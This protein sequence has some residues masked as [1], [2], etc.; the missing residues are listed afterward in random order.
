[1]EKKDVDNIFS[2]LK[3]AGVKTASAL[4]QLLS[5]SDTKAAAA[6]KGDGNLSARDR[7]ISVLD[8]GTFVETGAYMKRRAAEFDAPN[9]SPD[10]FEGVITGYGAVDGRLV[11]VFAQDFSR[12]KGAVSE[13]QAKK[14]AS[15]YK[16]AV[17]NGAPVIG[18]FDSAGAFVYDGIRAMSGFGCVMSCASSASGIVPQIALVCGPCS[19]SAA[20]IAGM[21]DFTVVSE[22]K[23]SVYVNSPFLLSQG[24]GSADYA[25]KTGFAALSA[26][27]DS[28]C[29][30]LLHTLINYLPMNNAE[31]TVRE[32]PK[33]E[34]NK[35]VDVSSVMTGDDYDMTALLSLIADSGKYLELY[36]GYAPEMTVGFIS[37]GGTVCGICANQPK[38]KS[39][40]L[41]PSASRKASRFVSF[42]DCFNIPVIT[43]VDS[44]GLDIS[45]EAEG[46]PYASELAK[47]AS[48]YA[49]AKTPLVTLIAGRAYGAVYT[50]MGSKSIGADVAFALDTAKIGAMPAQSAVAFLWNDKIGT[51]NGDTDTEYT[52]ESLEKQ[53]DETL[54]SAVEAAY[55]GEIDDIIDSSEIRQR[56]AAAVEMLSEKSKITPVKRHPNMPL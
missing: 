41:S 5:D 37:L 34:I 1:M 49:S 14:I 16:L 20:V 46:S 7:I 38:V 29:I 10:A 6:V 8:D 3:N 39:G 15:V 35:L 25:K 11:F 53:W 33:D 18:I 43:I 47:L 27:N 30:S 19:G 50:V 9:T 4:K 48:V 12:S 56:L 23:G 13:A 44:C 45:E 36:S 2:V 55:S 22:E 32:I 52:R 24:T 26:K 21:F 42:C 28:E 40:V 31:G 51:N 17:E 54:G